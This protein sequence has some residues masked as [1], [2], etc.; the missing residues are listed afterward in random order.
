MPLELYAEVRLSE[1]RRR[2]EGITAD[3]RAAIIE[4]H[5]DGSYEVEVSRPD[6]TTIAQFVADKGELELLNS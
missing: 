1:E 3:A 2:R 5:W 6:G 4:I